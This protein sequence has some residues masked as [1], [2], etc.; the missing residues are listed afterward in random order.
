MSD[1]A[2]VPLSS[3]LSSVLCGAFLATVACGGGTGPGYDD[4]SGDSP[5]SSGSGSV[6][7]TEV[8]MVSGGA[9]GDPQFDP[10][11]DTVSV[12]DTVTWTN[13]T[14]SVHT[15][16]ADGGSWNSGDVGGN[17]SFQRVFDQAGEYAYHC[18]YHGSPGS[19]MHGTI[20]VQ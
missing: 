16:T 2:T 10:Q 1:H 17:G 8:E 13:Q 19:G 5:E 3:L 20:V 15:V 7:G 6:A 11:V 12:G 4:G 9:Y 18:T 14:S